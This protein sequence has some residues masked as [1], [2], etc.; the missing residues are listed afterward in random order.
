MFTQVGFPI[1]AGGDEREA[2]RS[3]IGP[4][5]SIAAGADVET[6]R[7]DF[8]DSATVIKA[9]KHIVKGDVGI[10]FAI[11]HQSE[12]GPD[13]AVMGDLGIVEDFLS[14]RNGG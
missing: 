12:G 8:S 14:F 5:E 13:L 9:A 6:T 7:P 2:V 3:D 1:R 4:A 10:V 11:L